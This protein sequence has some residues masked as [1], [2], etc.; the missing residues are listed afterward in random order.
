MANIL[1]YLLWRGDLTLEQSPFQAVDGLVL[2][3]LSYTYFDMLFKENPAR[4]ISIRNAA[5]ELLALPEGT[6]RVR[7][8]IDLELLRL[9][10]KSRRFAHMELCYYINHVDVT[11]EAQFSAISIIMKED[12]VFVACRGTDSALVGWKEDLNMSFL[13]QVP[14]QVA[15]AKYLEYVAGKGFGEIWLGGHSKGGN[16]VIF[17]AAHV[18]EAVQE[19]IQKIYNYDGP[20]FRE[21]TLQKEGYQRIQPKIRTYVPQW[22]MVGM[23]FQYQEEYQVV[24]SAHKGILQHDPYSWEVLGT[25]F[26]YLDGIDESS[27]ILNQAVMEWLNGLTIEQRHKFVEAVYELLETYYVD[28]QGDLVLTPKHSFR[29]LQTLSGEDEETKEIIFSGL[30]LLI[31]ALKE[32]ITFYRKELYKKAEQRLLK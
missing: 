17:A 12:T 31:K 27:R 32:I 1:E 15:A 4:R 11:K 21:N 25:R 9:A 20:G 26:V 7:D 18:P 5:N 8:E 2:T 10:G 24:D 13:D 6:V 16:L 29:T 22:S 23:I 28:E 19:R 30:R 14:A 3:C